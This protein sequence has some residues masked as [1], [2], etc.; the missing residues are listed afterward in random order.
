MLWFA[1]V[2]VLVIIPLYL[3]FICN[4]S[5]QACKD[6]YP[7][8][9]T[10]SIIDVPCGVIIKDGKILLTKRLWNKEHALK[11]E[12]PGGKVEGSETNEQALVR[13]LKEELGVNVQ[14]GALLFKVDIHPPEV[15]RSC[16]VRLYFT[17][18]ISGTPKPLQAS[19]LKWFAPNELFEL[20]LCPANKKLLLEIVSYIRHY[21]ELLRN[22]EA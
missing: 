17:Q 3:I 12:I 13:E 2:I 7:S 8:F 6:I 14:V 19:E 15:K 9:L 22:N 18:I 4:L 10:T 11:W 21:N 1:L 16:C 5:D 20:A